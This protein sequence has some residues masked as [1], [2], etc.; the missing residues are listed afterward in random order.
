MV[1][2]RRFDAGTRRYDRVTTP[3]SRFGA[4][5][6]NHQAVPMAARPPSTAVTATVFS[7]PIDEPPA[8]PDNCVQMTKTHTQ[9]RHCVWVEYGMNGRRRIE[10]PRGSHTPVLTETQAGLTSV[11]GMGTGV[12]PPLWPP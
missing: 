2:D 1:A 4:S 9:R 6:A 8:R 3:L 11:F 10:F 5:T 12:A 7:S